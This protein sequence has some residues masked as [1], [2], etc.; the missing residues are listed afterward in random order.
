[1]KKIKS[2]LYQVYDSCCREMKLI[3]HDAGLLL[4][5]LFLP[6]IY[7]VLY[8]LIYN[9]E[10]VRDVK[11][12]VVDNDRTATSRRMVRDIDATEGARVIGYA[13]D[14]ADGRK[15][16]DSHKCFAI[17]EIPEGFERKIGRK[18]AAN[19]VMYCDMSLLLRYRSLLVATTDVSQQMGSEIT[20][21]RIDDIFGEASSI[22]HGDPMPI[23]NIALGNI[24]SGFDSFIMPGV[25]VLIL[26]QCLILCVGMI[27]GAKHER[28]MRYG[29]IPTAGG[30]SVGAAMTGQAIAVMMVIL[31]P[32]IFLIHYVPL[33]FRFPVETDAFTPFVFL[34]PMVLACIGLGFI[35]QGVVKERENVF[36]LWVATSLVFLFLCGITWPRYAMAPF[37]QLLG[38]CIPATWGVEGFIRISTNGA[39]ITQV[40]PCYI[41]L[42]IQAAVYMAIGYCVQRWGMRQDAVTFHT[43][44]VTGKDI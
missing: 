23:S 4:F 7:P 14:L 35:F 39:T 30:R 26:H 5:F 32:M 34:L 36:V 41:A 12:V 29:F 43:V 22:V 2:L 31:V 3:L 1:M 44:T 9:P 13:S 20:M 16:M 24:E 38:D 40:L 37:W 33:I 6:F 10:L 27:G 8:S 25:I 28:R 11:L 21:G 19:A 42:W 15:A 17:L 18:E